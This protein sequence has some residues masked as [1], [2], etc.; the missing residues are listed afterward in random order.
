M[1]QQELEQIKNEMKQKL[2][3]KM[4]P[5]YINIPDH[6]FTGDLKSSIEE[7]IRKAI[8]ETRGEIVDMMVEE[9]HSDEHF[10]RSIGLV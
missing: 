1:N 6:E 8:E 5:P 4:M 9:L 7:A 2:K 10:E 3:D